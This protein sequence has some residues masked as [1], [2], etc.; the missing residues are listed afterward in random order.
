MRKVLFLTCIIAGILVG[1]SSDD[2]IILPINVTVTGDG[3][4]DHFSSE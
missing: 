4:C 1:C 3:S 2:S